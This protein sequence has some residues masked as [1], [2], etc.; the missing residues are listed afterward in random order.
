MKLDQ[1]LR[2]GAE[3]PVPASLDHRVRTALRTMPL[4]DG[5]F[6]SPT[7]ALGLALA[8]TLARTIRLAVSF[9]AAGAAER[10]VSIATVVV[11]AYLGVAS[12]VS[13]P[14]LVKIRASQKAEVEA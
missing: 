1:L 11:V 7:L 5:R 14:L 13:L 2:N 12:V 8:A 10:G 9:A 3:R 4:P 6:A